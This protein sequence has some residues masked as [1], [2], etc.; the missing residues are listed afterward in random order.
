MSNRQRYTKIIFTIGPA[1]R[2]VATLERLINEGADI[3]RLNMAHASHDWT[4][5]TVARVRE[6]CKNAGR[7]IPLMM[8]VKGPEIRTGDLP[9]PIVLKEGDIVDFICQ[10]ENAENDNKIAYKTTVNYPDIN[11]DMKIGDTILVDSGLIRLVA[12]HVFNDRV[13]GRVIIPGTMG[14]RRHINL[15]GVRVNL[16]CLTEKDKGDIAVGIECGVEF[17]ALS[18]VRTADDLRIL[19][20]HLHDNKSKALIIAKI[21]D[22]TAISKLHSII[23]ATDALMIARGD[24]GIECPF[25]ELP[26]IQKRAV[27]ICISQGKPVI[28]ATHMLESMIE[29][30]IPTRAEVTDVSNAVFE[31][32]DCV[33]L[34][35]ETTT[36]KYPIQ[37]VQTM[38]RIAVESEKH[39]P[40]TYQT[41][42]ALTNPRLKMLRSAAL[43]AHDLDDA[44]LLVFTRS[45]NLPR[46]VSSL[47]PV[48]CPIFAFTDNPLTFRQ[49]NILWGVK[50]FFMEFPE[51]PEHT[52]QQAMKILYKNKWVHPEQWIVVISN[53][54]T[55]GGM[56]ESIQ[57]RQALTLEE[58][59]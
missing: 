45:G 40:P 28:V 57:M 5:E 31:R 18:F 21:E 47:R 32:A 50:P 48:G 39:L 16:P 25:E 42:R 24:L 3:C 52:I 51:L 2:E 10:K 15:P 29:N 20:K 46:I 22:Q 59:H 1:T 53:V 55:T 36:G 13:R 56:T 49:M 14:N 58:T 34:S 4:R 19:R 6:A 8:D 27:Q 26:T 44:S 35:G 12:T 54:L 23:R 43:L 9:A 33:M 11:K 30:P 38:H 41:E 17:F 7:D 37:S